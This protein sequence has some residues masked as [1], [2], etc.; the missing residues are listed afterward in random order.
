[1]AIFTVILQQLW[2]GW[3]LII[4]TVITLYFLGKLFLRCP[5]EQQKGL[6]IIAFIMVFALVFWAFD[7]QGGS[8]ISLFIERNVIKQLGSWSIPTANFQ[9]INPAG[10]LIGGFFVAWL[11]RYLHRKGIHIAALL[12]IAVGMLVLTFGFFFISWSAR[13][14]IPMGHVPMT[15]VV[16]GMLLIGLSELFID[17][18]A[19]AEIT[20]L[21]PANSVG[22]L[23]V[24]IC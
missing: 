12:K 2:V 8:S 9:S 14:A 7:Q 1:M 15:G 24:P 13:L 20:R 23:P 4:T 11:W 18:I 21:N 16:V 19:L 22:F 17:P 3:L 10:I 6:F 5:R